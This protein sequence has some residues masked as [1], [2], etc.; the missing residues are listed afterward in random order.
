MNNY[1]MLDGKKY[2]M[3]NDLIDALRSRVEPEPEDKSPFERE[4][5]YFFVTS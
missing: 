1:L 5:K 4:H 3:S 2:E